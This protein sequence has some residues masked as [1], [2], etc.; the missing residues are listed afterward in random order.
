MKGLNQVIAVEFNAPSIIIS[1][2]SK[3]EKLDLRAESFKTYSTPSKNV[4]KNIKS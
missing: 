1:L 4:P 3:K 2:I